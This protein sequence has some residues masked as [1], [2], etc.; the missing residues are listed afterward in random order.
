MKAFVVMTIARQIQGE[1]V[2]L[3]AEKGFTQ[4][5]KAD[6][7]LKELKK[8]FVTEYGIQKTTK[9]STTQGEME[10]MCEAGAFEIEIE[11]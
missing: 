8:T 11:D 10:C 9:L 6:E 7:Y 2:A 5:S 3:R 4:S 1:Y